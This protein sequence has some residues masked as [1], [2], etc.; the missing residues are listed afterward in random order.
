MSI[1]KQPVLYVGLK[2]EARL[3]TL[4]DSGAEYS[5]ISEEHIDDICTVHPC[6]RRRFAT[7]SGEH[8]LEVKGMAHLN[9]VINDVQ[10]DDVFYIVSELSEEAI[11]GATTMQKWRI[12]LNFGQDTIEVKP[13]LWEPKLGKIIAVK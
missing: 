10:L 4:F 3:Y 2:N 6:L 5:C 13:R 9:F 11:I 7:A 8:F 12:K 1:I